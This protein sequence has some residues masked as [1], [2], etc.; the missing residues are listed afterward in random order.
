MLISI[1]LDSYNTFVIITHGL[2]DAIAW[3]WSEEM[4]GRD[5]GEGREGKAV[6]GR[7][8]TAGLPSY[9]STCH[10]SFRIRYRVA[11]S[12]TYAQTEYM[13]FDSEKSNNFGSV[14]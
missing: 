13:A 4:E 10:F 2:F 6:Q 1:S 12:G 9:Y 5:D 14:N 7:P 11:P 8:K 3:V